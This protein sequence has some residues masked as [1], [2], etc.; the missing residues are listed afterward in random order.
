MYLSVLFIKIYFQVVKVI[1][2]CGHIITMK[3]KTIPE[4]ILCTK[5]CERI[6]DCGHMCK[7]VCANECTTKDCEEIVLQKNSKLAC[8]HNSVWVLCCDKDK[9]IICYHSIITFFCF[10]FGIFLDY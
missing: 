4:R 7:K 3:C 6:L 5:K 8:G 1:P 10:K 9:G 2:D